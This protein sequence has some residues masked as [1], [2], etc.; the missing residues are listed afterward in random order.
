MC[1]YIHTHILELV[2][3]TFS[4]QCKNKMD[5][6]SR[7]YKCISQTSSNDSSVYN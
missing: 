7:V 3:H 1:S 5:C 6:D 4:K 2:S